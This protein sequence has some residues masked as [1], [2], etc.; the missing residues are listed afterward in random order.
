MENNEEAASKE[1]VLIGAGLPRTGTLSTRYYYREVDKA[2]IERLSVK[3]GTEYPTTGKMLPHGQCH[4]ESPR[5]SPLEESYP[6]AGQQG[7]LAGDPWQAG[8]QGRRGLS[9]VSVL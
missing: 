6:G 3:G 1:F 2:G 5:S 9:R 4:G 8:V 7:G